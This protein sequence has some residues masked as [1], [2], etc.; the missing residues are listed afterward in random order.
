MRLRQQ[1][2]MKTAFSTG[3]ALYEWIVL[4]FGLKT[5]PASFQRFMDRIL[6]GIKFKFTYGFLDDIIIFSKTWKEHVQ[7]IKMVLE[8]LQRYNAKIKLEKCKWAGEEISFLG[9][10]LRENQLEMDPRKVQ[11]I[12]NAAPP[13]NVKAVQRFLGMTGYYRRFIRNY[14]QIASPLTMLTSAKVA[15]KW[16]KEQ[17]VAFNQLKA[18]LMSKPIL[19]QPNFNNIALGV[20]LSQL[21]NDVSSGVYFTKV[22]RAREEIL[23]PRERSTRNR[24]GHR[25]APLL[26]MGKEIYSNI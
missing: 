9:H 15:W 2:R 25:E 12:M 22:I 26:P 10:I 6:E 20:V 3:D 14:S 11:G 17:E 4:P 18:A 24:M 19:H 23:Y 21:D 5:A 13:N 8:R 1:D 16:E 7:H